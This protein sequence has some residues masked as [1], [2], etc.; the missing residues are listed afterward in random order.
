VTIV[1]ANPED[2]EA[3]GHPFARSL[4][5]AL[6]AAAVGGAVSGQRGAGP[7]TPSGS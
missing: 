2:L 3:D 4:L 1:L 5:R 6:G 7:K